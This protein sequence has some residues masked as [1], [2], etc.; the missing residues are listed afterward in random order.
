MGIDGRR[1]YTMCITRVK[2][3]NQASASD[4]DSIE[5]NTVIH[6]RANSFA[7]PFKTFI[8][9]VLGSVKMDIL[10]SGEKSGS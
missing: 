3:I 6:V 7:L 4:W 5:I 1:R 10:T 2:K 9:K 8:F